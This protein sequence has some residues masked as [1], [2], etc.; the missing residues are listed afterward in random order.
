[1]INWNL[2]NL[3]TFKPLGFQSV[4]RATVSCLHSNIFWNMNVCKGGFN[5]PKCSKCEYYKVL[6]DMS[7]KGSEERENLKKE[8]KKHNSREDSWCNI[9]H[10]WRHESQINPCKVLKIIHNEM[11]TNKT[12]SMMAKYSMSR[13][14][15]NI[16]IH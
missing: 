14:R 7:M 5:F 13:L 4:S 6:I 8:L 10:A 12:T 3:Q 1:M 9:Y 2:C 15:F 16:S 11:D